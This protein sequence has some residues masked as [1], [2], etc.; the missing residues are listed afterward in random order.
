MDP[1]PWVGHGHGM[2]AHGAGAAGVVGR[3]ALAGHE[4]ED[5][6]VTPGPFTRC[7]LRAAE[8]VEGR[9]GHDFPGLADGLHPFAALL[10]GR[11]VVEPDAGIDGRIG[12]SDLHPSANVGIHGTDVHL[13]AVSPMGRRAV[14]AD[15]HRQEVELDVGIGHP[16]VATDEAAGLEMVGGRLAGAAEQ[17]F[18]T[19]PRLVVPLERR[20]HADRLFAG[21]L[22]VQLEV[23]LQVAA[24]PGKILDNTDAKGIKMVG[25]PHPGKLQQLRRIDGPAATD[26]FATVG[27]VHLAAL[28]VGHADG[29]F[30]LEQDPGNQGVA[31]DRQVATLLDRV[32]IGSCRIP[33][34]AAIGGAV[35]PAEALLLETVDIP[36]ER[37]AR[38]AD[39]HEKCIEQGIVAAG[40]GQ[41]KGACRA[42][43]GIGADHAA[44]DAFEIGQAV[45]VGPVGQA[46][47]LGPFLVIHGVAANVDHAVN[48]AGSAQHLAPGLVDPAVMHE[49]FGIG[50][51]PPV[52]GTAGERVS[53]GRGHVDAKIE[54]MV[55]SAGFQH[56]YAVPGMGAQPVGQNGSGRTAADDNK[57]VVFHDDLPSGRSPDALF[58]ASAA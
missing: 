19:D 36:G 50:L 49:G 10:V 21:I 44:L 42:R 28:S 16:V 4:I 58:K 17:P 53:Q 9:L 1:Q 56:Q 15:G 32:D 37:I 57:I 41:I 11:E 13:V 52:I 25:R 43:V 8:F 14:V 2:G 18:E 33:A 55:R 54:A 31:F 47:F 39:S 48:A 51:V 12:G 40:R 35:E 23:V 6:L 24:H 34:A 45:G 20:I 7:Q 22:H 27:V 26:N 29:A 38:L 3:F 30:T 46:V 5:V